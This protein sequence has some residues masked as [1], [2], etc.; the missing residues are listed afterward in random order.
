MVYGGLFLL[1]YILIDS[2]CFK[3][4]PPLLIISLPNAGRVAYSVDNFS[5]ESNKFV[6]FIRAKALIISATE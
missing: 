6:L 1:L 2:Y 3:D 4:C 5:I